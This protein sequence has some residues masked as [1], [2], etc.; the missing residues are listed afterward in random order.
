[1]NDTTEIP[2][3]ET[4]LTRQAE[5]ITADEA[6]CRLASQSALR[7]VEVQGLTILQGKFEKTILLERVTFDNLTIANAEFAE[8]VILGKCRIGRIK[9]GGATIFSQGAAFRGCTLGHSDLHD[10][11]FLQ[12][13]KLDNTHFQGNLTV[14]GCEFA[15]L[16]TWA[17]RF[18]GWVEFHQC[19]FSGVADF[20]SFDCEQGFQSLDCVFQNDVLFRGA[21]VAKRF[22]LGKSEFHALLDLS[23][24][25]LHDFAYLEEIKPGKN[26]GICVLNG[27]FD[28]MQIRPE[29][30][31]GCLVSENEKRHRDAMFE[32]GLLKR[33]FE[34]QHRYAD[35]DWA[36]YRFK[37]N[38]RRTRKLSIFHLR[39]SLFRFLDFLFLDLAC[40]Y[41]AKPF[42]AV[43]SAFVIILAFAL[44]YAG[45]ADLLKNDNTPIPQFANAHWANRGTLAILTSVSVFTAGFTGDH[46]HSATGWILL[47][48]AIEALLGTLLLGLFIVAFSRQVI[49]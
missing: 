33:N 7:D 43:K 32:F 45:G 16:K 48:M 27:L 24:A 12:S 6:L 3:T 15:G 30:I 41:G 23:K 31:D 39:S 8:R 20:R 37:I 9:I 22:D 34:S 38:Q 21:M 5:I 29:Q 11:K 35:E 13:F 18:S 10:S 25:K 49:R 36:F 40:G 14:K 4:V 17:T 1:M 42:R 44:L 28:R 47:P 19:Q 2:E 46:L 26:F